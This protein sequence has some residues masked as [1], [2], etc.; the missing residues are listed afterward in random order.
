MAQVVLH[1]NY[2]YRVRENISR[3]QSTAV[4]L[5]DGVIEFLS[6]EAPEP[7]LDQLL[8]DCQAAREAL[9]SFDPKGVRAA[10]QLATTEMLLLQAKK[11]IDQTLAS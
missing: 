10:Q 4:D 11:M 2:A 5:L 8:S 9:A 7:E 1:P 6:G 3:T